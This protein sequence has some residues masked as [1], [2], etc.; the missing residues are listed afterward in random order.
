MEVVISGN[1]LGTL[2][3]LSHDGEKFRWVSDIPSDAWVFG[4]EDI[5]RDIGHVALATGKEVL[6]FSSSPYGRSNDIIFGKSNVNIPWMHVLPSKAF[7]KLLSGILDQLW[8]VLDSEHDSYYMNQFLSNRELLMKLQ[9]PHIDVPALREI[10]KNKTAKSDEVLKFLPSHGEISPK[11]SYSQINSITGRLTVKSGPNILTLKR[12]HRK[13]L[14]SR[15]SSGKIIQIDISS[16]EPRIA[17]SVAGKDSPEDIYNFVGKNV[18]HNRLTRDQVKIAVLSCMYGASSW[19]LSKNL[20]AELDAKEILYEIKRYF[21]ISRLKSSLEK[22]FELLGH[23]KNL[24]KRPI[25][26]RDS[27]VNHYLQSSGVDVSFNVFS[28]ILESLSLLKIDFVPVYVIHDAIVLDIRSQ[29]YDKIIELTKQ[30]YKVD[31]LDCIFPVKVE[32]IKE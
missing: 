31:N 30:G 12:E 10:L 13:I 22:E 5:V 9:S 3:H 20:P 19:S 25:M 23:I 21:K 18:L 4:S 17:L 32:V 1:I 11:T 7:H 26:S 6:D 29:D 24:Y 27:V 14:K 2:N 8:C 28:Q 15:F 16:L